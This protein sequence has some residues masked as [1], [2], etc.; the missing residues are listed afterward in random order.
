MVQTYGI[1]SENDVDASGHGDV[2]ESRALLGG[3]GSSGSSRTDATGVEKPDGKATLLSCA[4]NL[5]NTIMGTGMWKLLLL[6]GLLL[7]TRHTGMLTFPMVS[8]TLF[9]PVLC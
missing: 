1:A 4:S 9:R 5:S 6:A 7:L 3:A 8:L 2:D